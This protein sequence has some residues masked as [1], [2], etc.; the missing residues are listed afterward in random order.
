MEH[1]CKQGTIGNYKLLIIKNNKGDF[2]VGNR[3][4]KTDE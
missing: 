1:N 4:K 3:C 2:K